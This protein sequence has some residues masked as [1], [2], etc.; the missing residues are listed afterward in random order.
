MK[1]KCKYYVDGFCK[2]YFTICFK[3]KR[4]TDKHIHIDKRETRHA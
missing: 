3:C 2:Y 4:Y 1:T